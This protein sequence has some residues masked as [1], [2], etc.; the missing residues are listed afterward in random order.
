MCGFPA[1]YFYVKAVSE[2]DQT[3]DLKAFDVPT[4]IMR[5]DDDQIVPIA[6]SAMRSAK[7]VKNAQS[8][9]YKGA[10]RTV[11][12]RRTRTRSI[13]ICSPLSNRKWRTGKG[14]SRRGVMCGEH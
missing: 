5:G 3:G 4:L 8:K 10:H 7:L 11:C 2:P 12:A 14:P 1:A 6:A 13:P 9:V